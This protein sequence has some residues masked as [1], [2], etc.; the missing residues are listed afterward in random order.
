MTGTRRALLIGAGRYTDERLARLQAPTRDTAALAEILADPSIGDYTVD[1]LLDRPTTEV[2]PAVIDLLGTAGPDDLVVIYFSGH[3]LHDEQRGLFLTTVDSRADDLAATALSAERLTSLVRDSHSGQVIFVADCHTLGTTDLGTIIDL[4]AAG[5]FASRS[6]IFA[7][8][9]AEELQYSFTNSG[10]PQMIDS[11][12]R[13][14]F[15]QALIRTLRTGT[16]DA[17]GDGLITPVE[18]HQAVVAEMSRLAPLTMPPAVVVT[19]EAF[20]ALVAYAPSA[21]APVD[22][23]ADTEW[24]VRTRGYGDRPPEVDLLDRAAAVDTL[25]ELVSPRGS[26][27]DDLAGP[28]VIALDGAWGTGKTSLIELTER[29]V[30]ALP[31]AVDQAERPKRLRAHAAYRALGGNKR[32]LWTQRMMPQAKENTRPPVV[33]ARFEPWAHQTG[34]Q[35]WA[36]LAKTLLD[37]VGERLLPTG[38]AA[39][40]RYWFQRNIERVDRTRLRKALRKNAWSPLLTAAVLALVIPIAAQMARSMDRYVLVRWVEIAG[41]NIAV[42]LIVALLAAGAAHTAYRYLKPATALLPTDLFVGPLSNTLAGN[43][44]DEDLRDPYHNARSGYLYLAQHDV[45]AVLRDV[46]AAGHHLVVFID[47]LDRCA[48][49]TTAEVF[50][51]INLFVTRTFPVTRFVLCLDTTAVATHLDEVHSALQGKTLHGD[52]PTPGWSFLR[53]L[54]QLPITVPTVSHSAVGGVLGNL[55]GSVAPT[56]RRPLAD[57][58]EDLPHQ[59]VATLSPATAARPSSPEVT[60]TVSFLEHDP[61][62][63]ERMAERLRDQPAPS[64]RETKRLLTTWQYYLRVLIRRRGTAQLVEEARQLV[65]LAEIITRWPSA[66]RGLHRRVDGEHGLQVLAQ[67]MADDWQWARALRQLDLHTHQQHKAVAGIRG[68]L[69]RYEGEQLAK[70]A[71]ELV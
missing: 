43:P 38:D 56:D 67:G 62:V 12:G 26:G 3:V 61:R 22:D 42:L 19:P 64:V 63:R 52:D 37:A 2:I 59:H 48:P 10:I 71:A 23:E 47:D 68:L 6:G 50:E 14:L 29:Q 44:T 66:Q 54:I 35:V 41:S 9:S 70:L 34:E 65:V 53:K 49:S 8:V 45:F 30:V 33:T 21:L 60:K 55:L 31:R 17:D 13:S 51:A 36:G 58:V 32:P 20:R 4:T 5:S 11:P 24:V 25:V 1:V 46:E 18:L 7:M 57:N 15:V 40:E 28:T 69:L 16:A 39:T 27:P